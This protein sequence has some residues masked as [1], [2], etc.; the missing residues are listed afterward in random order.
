MTSDKTFSSPSGAASF[1]LG[2]N[3]NG[4]TEW[5]NED[6]Y[7]LASIYKKQSE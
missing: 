3:A 6:G 5:K 2:H 4:W 1:C 7:T